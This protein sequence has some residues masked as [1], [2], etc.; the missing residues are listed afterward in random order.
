MKIKNNSNHWNIFN[1]EVPTVIIKKLQI[2]TPIYYK[3]RR[4]EQKI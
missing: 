3:S 1:T 4:L 2:H